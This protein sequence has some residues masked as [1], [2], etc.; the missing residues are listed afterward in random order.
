MLVMLITG[1]AAAD[2]VN[3]GQEA[4][5]ITEEY[6]AKVLTSDRVPVWAKQQTKAETTL[7]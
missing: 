3:N 7:S 2:A 4:P 6:R 1:Y 5:R